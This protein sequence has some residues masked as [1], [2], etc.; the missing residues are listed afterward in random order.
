M[1]LANSNNTNGRWLK[2]ALSWIHT[3]FQWV[4]KFVNQ[5]KNVHRIGIIDIFILIFIL[6]GELLIK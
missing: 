6:N 4:K 3:P 1:L 5:T 2:M